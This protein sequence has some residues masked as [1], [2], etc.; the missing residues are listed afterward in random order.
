[1]RSRIAGVVG[2]VSCLAAAPVMASEGGGGGQSLI[3]PNFGTIFWTV[4]TFLFFAF[5]LGRFAWRPMLAALNERER[6]IRESIDRARSERQAAEQLAA[7]QRELLDEARRER[8]EAMAA[9][10]RD[11][12]RLKAE[13]LDEA[14]RQR[15]QLLEQTEAQVQAGMRQARA[16]LR[17]E[18][19]DLALQA[20]EKLIARNLDDATQRRLVEDYLADLEKREGPT[21]PP[22]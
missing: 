10:Q 4:V 1:M 16:E 6:S 12:E 7:E 22:S 15:D 9:G 3:E 2:A 11:A 18:V 20:A 14:R 19:V 17:S 5:I 21:S 13:I 8:A